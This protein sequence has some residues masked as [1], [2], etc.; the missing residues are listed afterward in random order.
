MAD[1]PRK[2]DTDAGSEYE[3][4]AGIPRWLKVVVIIVI[5]LVLLVVVLMLTGVFGGEHTPGPPPGGH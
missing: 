5:I 3:S 4:T 2:P 1:P